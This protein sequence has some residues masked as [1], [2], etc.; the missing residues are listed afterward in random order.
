MH[1]QVIDRQLN[2]R[3]AAR[4][5]LDIFYLRSRPPLGSECGGGRRRPGRAEDGEVQFRIGQNGRAGDEQSASAGVLHHDD[6][7]RG[8]HGPQ[9]VGNDGAHGEHRHRC[10]AAIRRRA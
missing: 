4:Q 10:P 8:R 3:D 7:H 9:E 6:R 1:A 2:A 5:P